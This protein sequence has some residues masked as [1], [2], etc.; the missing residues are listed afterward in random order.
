MSKKIEWSKEQIAFIEEGY[1]AGWPTPYIAKKVGRT[2]EQVR[3]LAAEVG[4]VHAYHKKHTR[5]RVTLPGPVR[6]S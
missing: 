6:A 2:V 1:E 5:T 4:L 3:K